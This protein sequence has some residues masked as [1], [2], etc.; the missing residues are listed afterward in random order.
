MRWRSDGSQAWLVCGHH[1][2]HRSDLAHASIYEEVTLNLFV[3]AKSMPTAT[4]L[5]PNSSRV[6]DAKRCRRAT[7]HPIP[8]G[9]NPLGNTSESPEIRD[10]DVGSTCVAKAIFSNTL[11]ASRIDQTLDRPRSSRPRSN[12]R[13]VGLRSSTIPSLKQLATWLPQERP[14]GG[15]LSIL[16]RLTS[17]ADSKREAFETD[18]VAEHLP[19]NSGHALELPIRLTCC[20]NGRYARRAITNRSRNLHGQPAN[21]ARKRHRPL[22]TNAHSAPRPAALSE[23]IAPIE[24]LSCKLK[25]KSLHLGEKLAGF[26]ALDA[27]PCRQLFLMT[28][29]RVH[30]SVSPRWVARSR[31]AGMRGRGFCAVCRE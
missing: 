14:Q 27:F 3:D 16:L 10:A 18:P 22:S 2:R 26:S 30:L 12:P 1:P 9:R 20:V 7:V 21:H 15:E 6:T 5:V 31:A 29:F 8:V 19:T 24:I 17:S 13:S 23:G 28:R 4:R 11:Q 25:N